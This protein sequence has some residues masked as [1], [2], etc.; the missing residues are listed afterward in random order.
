MCVIILKQR[1]NHTKN[2]YKTDRHKAGPKLKV[3]INKI[4]IIMDL[5]SY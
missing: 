3:A 2:T 1:R 5:R 4:F